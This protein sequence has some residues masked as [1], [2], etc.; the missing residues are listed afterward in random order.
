L[1]YKPKTFRYY[2]PIFI[3]IVLLHLVL[4]K[5]GY[6]ITGMAVIE[7]C[8]I[9]K[10]LSIPDFA[11]SQNG[12]DLINEIQE[13][14]ENYASINESAILNWTNNISS[15]SS[16]V[17]SMIKVWYK[18][19]SITVLWQNSTSWEQICA[20]PY[21]V[22]ETEYSCN[23][24]SYI[25]APEKANNISLKL[26]ANSSLEI[27]YAVLNISVCRK[28]VP[29]DNDKDG[30]KIND[31]IDNCPEKNNTEQLDY[32]EDGKG[33][34]CDRIWGYVS[35]IDSNMSLELNSTNNTYVMISENG[36]VVLE[37]LWNETPPL[38]LEN[39][40]IHKQNESKS[41]ILI[42]G[43]NLTNSTKT[44]YLDMMLNK[45]HVCV[46][47]KEYVNISE[48]T[49]YCNGKDEIR[50]RC[51]GS[52]NG[53]VC[54]IVNNSYKISGLK[55]SFVFETLI[56]SG[57]GGGTCTPQWQCTAWGDCELGGAKYRECSDANNCDSLQNKPEES[58]QCAAEELCSN[59]F[60][61]VG[62]EG[63]DC[64]GFCEPCIIE[65]IEPEEPKL[66]TSS[67][68]Q[69]PAEIIEEM[70]CDSLPS[71]YYIIYVFII[72]FTVIITI[73]I[74]KFAPTISRRKF[75]SGILVICNLILV[76]ILGIE[77]F[78]RATIL[79]IILLMPPLVVSYPL[80]R[81]LIEKHKKR[82][83][84]H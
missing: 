59:G 67:A 55:H 51:P 14:D 26:V 79:S 23:I 30:D 46:F 66:V 83:K 70:T 74:K 4:A 16:I 41:S 49:T 8:I 61:D 36:S 76:L 1:G 43:I 37:F 71:A 9:S 31:K 10:E 58:M 62:E 60:K 11:V 82:K 19:G 35:D 27:D 34:E 68:P 72:A 65:K 33:D 42:Q 12:T 25:D 45:R 81:I 48:S 2:I 80:L 56:K 63:I 40:S 50:I 39:I 52:S 20:I 7:G 75:L 21:T 73:N 6:E 77:I 17:D 5:F 29:V 24:S 18:N 84:H 54:E 38:M 64:G 13:L 47:D 28:E 78:C 69:T 57:G 22:N 3:S 53:Y 44:V 32:D 15:N